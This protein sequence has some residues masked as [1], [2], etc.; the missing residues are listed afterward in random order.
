M[1]RITIFSTSARRCLAAVVLLF[2]ALLPVMAGGATSRYYYNASAQV[3][4]SGSGKVYV[5]DE[6]SQTPNYQTTSSTGT[7]NSLTQNVTF[8]LYAQPSEGYLFEKWQRRTRNYGDWT[9]LTD[10]NNSINYAETVT[11]TDDGSPDRFYYQAVFKKQEGAVKVA[12]AEEG[13]GSVSISNPD[14]RVGQTVTLTAIP[15]AANGIHFLGWNKEKNNTKPESFISTVTPYTFQITDDNKGT[16]YAH[17]SEAPDNIYCR[18]QNRDTHRFLTLYGHKKAI[19]HKRTVDNTEYNDGF[20]FDNSLKLIDEDDAIGN[21]MTVFLRNG[22]P[23]GEGITSGANLVAANSIQYHNLVSDDEHTNLYQLTMVK[24][25]KGVQ[26]Y[27]S[28]STRVD[29]NDLT[30]NT[31]LTDEE[32]GDYAVMQSDNSKNIYWDV[33]LL[34]ED[35]NEAGSFRAY[36]KPGFG[37]NG[38][39]GEEGMYYTTMY[40]YFPYKLM[41]GVKA[42]YL[43]LEETSYDEKNKE[44][45]FTELADGIVPRYSAVV[46]EC[47]EVYSETS[48]RLLPLTTKYFQDL[49]E[50]EPSPLTYPNSNLL[51]GYISLYDKGK[52]ANDSNNPNKVTNNKK[53]MFILSK[54]GQDLG[55][56]YFT[57]EYMTPNKAYLDLSPWEDAFHEHQ[58]EAREIEFV[59]GKGDEEEATGVIAPKY[60]EKVDG[61]L[62]DL[63]GRR[64]TDGDAYGLKKGI[65]ISN[66]KKIVIK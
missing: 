25:N 33:Y 27:T 59:F 51:N 44:V 17:F 31:Y 18:I 15:D 24:T 5:S 12:V 20:K 57:N 46:L 10:N 47:P 28:Y 61:A 38:E 13:R 14:N 11:S 21:P 8:Y 49:G 48:N 65:Y 60:A 32:N 36:A 42:Y 29:G 7:Q 52:D 63:N 58:N 16:Y 1:K 6:A 22:H 9:D 35:N 30:F 2:V 53:T 37:G 43:P 55:W 26:I 64:V 19:A 34:E 62:F 66:G 41:D 39:Y 23:A 45:H 4:P 54:I 40:T 3:T 56:F 50:S